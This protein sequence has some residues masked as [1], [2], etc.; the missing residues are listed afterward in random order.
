MCVVIL[1]DGRGSRCANTYLFIQCYH[2]WYFIKSVEVFAV[3]PTNWDE[4]YSKNIMVLD[5]AKTRGK[6]E[7]NY[8]FLYFAGYWN[9]L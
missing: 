9:L 6:S 8:L 1:G 2:W 7:K 4:Q 5:A 3:L